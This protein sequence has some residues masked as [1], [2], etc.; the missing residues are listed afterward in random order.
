LCIRLGQENFYTAT[1]VFPPVDGTG[2]VR[3][4]IDFTIESEDITEA[5]KQ[6]PRWSMCDSALGD[7]RKLLEVN[8]VDLQQR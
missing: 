6:L 4:D 8:M 3:V 5:T 1:F 7:A 2:Y